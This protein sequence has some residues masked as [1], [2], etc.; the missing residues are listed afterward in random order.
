MRVLG[1]DPGSRLTGFGV[2]EQQGRALRALA[3]GVVR[4]GAGDLA[5]RLASLVSGIEAVVE[6]WQPEVIA[7]ECAF[8]GKSM[9]S[10]LRLGEVRGAF[11]AF[12][13]GRGLPVFDYPPATVKLTVAG[14]GNAT[15]AVVA[16]AVAG[17]LGGSHDPGDAAD[18]LAVALCHLQQGS[19]RSRVVEVGPRRGRIQQAASRLPPGARFVRVSR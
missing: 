3:H 13:G 7:L 4:P 15:K 8:V 12:A 10:A 14:I 5:A 1:I 17:T 11:L 9:S 18:A 19:F 16:R 6:E 2:V